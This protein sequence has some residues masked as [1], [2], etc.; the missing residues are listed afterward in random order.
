MGSEFGGE[1]GSFAR[2]M[3]WECTL[4]SQPAPFS[5]QLL[6]DAAVASAR[7]LLE[8]L[9]ESAAAA[10][11]LSSSRHLELLFAL[12]RRIELHPLAPHLA[13]LYHARDGGKRMARWRCQGNLLVFF[14]FEAS[15]KFNFT[16][17]RESVKF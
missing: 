10:L 7:R 9:R 17:K 3:I 1:W 5:F 4:H 15:H 8:Q 6:L 16:S 2:N 14:T 13:H 12:R 11:P